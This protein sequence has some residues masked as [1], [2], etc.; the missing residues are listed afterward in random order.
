MK[1]LSEQI[2]EKYGSEAVFYKMVEEMSELT[3]ALCHT[4]E[5]RENAENEVCEEIADCSIVIDHLNLIFEIEDFEDKTFDY[6]LQDLERF[7][8]VLIGKIQMSLFNN[9]DIEFRKIMMTTYLRQ[10][11]TCLEL[12]AEKYGQKQVREWREIKTTRIKYKLEHGEE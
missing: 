8:I 12:L 10:F 7:S 6:N 2:V 4:Y 3:T 11:K 5:T 9:S 1:S